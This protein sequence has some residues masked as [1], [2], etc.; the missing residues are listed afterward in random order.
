MKHIKVVLGANFGDEGKGMTARYFTREGLKNGSVLNV[1]FNGGVQRGHTAAGHVFHCFGSG[2]LDGAVTYYTPSFMVNPIGWNIETNELGFCPQL[3]I[4][5]LSRVTTPFDIAINQAIEKKRNKNR[6]GSCGMGILET[7][8][9]SEKLPIHMKDLRDEFELY[10]KLKYIENE[11]YPKRCEELGVEVEKISFDDF[12]TSAY[13]MQTKGSNVVINT[14]IKTPLH[15][16]NT[17]VYEGGQGLLLSEDNMDY[18]PHLTPS[19]TGSQVIS[20]EIDKSGIKD[21]EV[22]Y[23]TRSYMTRHGAGRF[24]TECDKSDINPFIIDKTN[25]PNDY[26]GSL[27]FGYINVGGLKN[28]IKRD[29]LNY[30]THPELSIAVTQLN[31][32]GGKICG[33][34]GQMRDLSELSSLGKIYKSY[35]EDKLWL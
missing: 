20:R 1:L 13:I 30:N 35:E 28:R 23:V 2:A 7:R 34:Y 3:I 5:P 8:L 33:L 25:M 27:R 18:F 19:F 21:V 32:T 24:D 26:Q 16:F 29:F 17:T 31:Y 9:R 15:A 10:K 12:M 14:D 11:Y 22:C 6:H 4:N